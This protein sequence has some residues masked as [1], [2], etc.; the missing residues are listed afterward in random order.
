MHP[1]RLTSVRSIDARGPAPISYNPGTMTD[2]LPA[3]ERAV[4]AFRRSVRG[5]PAGAYEKCRRVLADLRVVAAEVFGGAPEN[6]ALADGHTATIDRVA[7]T[8][9]QLLLHDRRE[10]ISVVST[11]SE[12]IGGLGAFTADPRFSVTT[13]PPGELH[14]TRA[15][16]YFLSHLTYD[17]NRDLSAEIRAVSAR[18]EGLG[19]GTLDAPIVVVDGTQAAGQVDVDVPSLGAHAWLSSAHKWLGGPHGSGLL[20]LKG[21]FATKWP[22]P[23]RAGEP[24]C[25]DLPIG[26]WEPRGGQDFARVAGLAAALR[27]FQVHATPGGEVRATF[28]A[29]L[30]REL[31]DCV[32][33]LHSSAENGRVI[34]FEM[35]GTDVYPVYRRL[36][37]RG[38]SVKCIKRNVPCAETG[39][40]CLEVIRLGLPWWTDEAHALEGVRA[41]AE[42]MHQQQGEQG[43]TA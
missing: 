8:I 26:R 27:A 6:W 25:G 11:D 21:D 28:I 19:L 24:L 5:H 20:Y 41:I 12:H 40:D 2:P 31:G 17:T 42:T 34:A 43:A 16:V 37:E 23:Y 36:V 13:V 3:V 30:E 32:R 35:P 39:R 14:A 29:E 18:G 9:G 4:A 7:S 10:R 1:R 22:T 38:I 33:V 15:Q